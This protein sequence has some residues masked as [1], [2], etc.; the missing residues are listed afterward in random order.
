MKARSPELLFLAL[1]L[2]V[3]AS[4]T[5]TRPALSPTVRGSSTELKETQIVPTLETPLVKGKN[6]I[7]CASFLAA[8]KALEGDSIPQKVPDIPE[9][10]LYT[11]AGVV[12][13]GSTRGSEM[14]ETNIL[15]ELRRR[16][17]E[18]LQAF[19]QRKRGSAEV[20]VARPA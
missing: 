19:A 12:G 13:D 11:A 16:I 20:A 4:C 14:H 17:D 7:W 2:G 1:A 15:H 9:G 3:G 5:R 18:T 6:A 8:W 10:A